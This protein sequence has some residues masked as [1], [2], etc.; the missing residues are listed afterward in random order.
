MG[1][2]LMDFG[3]FIQYCLGGITLGSIYA[4]VGIGFN[5]IYNTTGIINF[6]QGEFLV[7]G[8]L[9]AI[10][11]YA[12]LPLPLAI[13]LAIILT[14]IVGA[15]VEI[16]FIKWIAKPTVLRLIIITI[17]L[18]ILM[19]E[20]MLHI[21]HEDPKS[22]TYFTGDANSKIYILGAYISPQVLWVLGTAVIVVI[23][24]NLFFKLT[25]TGKA[26]RAC[27]SNRTAASLCGIN[28]SLMVTLSFMISAA[29]GA[30]AGC[31]VAPSSPIGYDSG[32][33]FAVKGFTVAILGGLGN[34]MAAT[35]GGLTLGLL[36]SFS[37]KFFPSAYQDL[38]SLTILILILFFKPSGLFGSKE[39]SS[40]KEY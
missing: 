4:I 9:S 12:F 26:M 28:T 35:I 13:L 38:V 34:S 32:S 20:G 33:A 8:A 25:L 5:I 7:L 14:S 2:K 24:L 40:L 10:T 27:A 37:I 30:V 31:V 11:F 16:I 15:L 36:E 18:S 22:F 19:R 17:G 39:E 23:I 6:A 29:I 3:F 21:F 1:R